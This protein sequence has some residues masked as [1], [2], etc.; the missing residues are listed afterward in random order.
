[1]L[2]W[3]SHCQEFQGEAPPYDDLRITH[4]ICASCEGVIDAFDA[5]D[6][7]H[8]R[9]LQGIQS[10]LMDAGARSDAQ[11]AARVIEDASKARVRAVDALMGIVAPMLY[12]IGVQWERAVLSV[13]DEHR[14]TAFCEEL[15]SLVS[16]RIAPS[17]RELADSES[18]VVMNAP[19]NHHVLGLRILTLWLLD[20]GVRA[21]VVE[22]G[23]GPDDIVVLVRQVKPRL[24]LVS[25]A[26][27]EQRPA[28]VEVATAIA[29]LP[30]SIRPTVV[31]GGYAVKMG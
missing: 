13:E 27:P 1:M 4:G 25:I 30:E 29:A 10:R 21:W 3:C 8:A 18:V 9:T 20:R 14:F 17:L 7:A 6:L 19:G 26:L 11:L 23:K 15:F 24:V 5:S 28:V 22:P 2:R 16:E 12:E 31:V